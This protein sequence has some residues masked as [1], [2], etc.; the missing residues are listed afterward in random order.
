MKKLNSKE[1]CNELKAKFKQQ[2]SGVTEEDLKCFNGRK[3]VMLEK[4]QQ[5]LVITGDELHKIILNL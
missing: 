3:E 4:L 2:Y 5:K 1:N